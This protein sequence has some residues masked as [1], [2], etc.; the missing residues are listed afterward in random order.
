MR[1][2]VTHTEV[3]P[4]SSRFRARTKVRE[5]LRSIISY[6]S[7][8]Y[9]QPI[10]ECEMAKLSGMSTFRFSKAFRAV[11]GITFRDYLSDLRLA[12]S[13]R[14]LEN[15]RISVTDV[16]ALSGFNDPSYFA[17]LFRAKVGVSPTSYRLSKRPDN[18]QA[19]VSS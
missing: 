15:P 3:L 5:R 6:I 13:R 16:A 9:T 4:E 14:L 10:T 11:Y 17:R 2:N 8:H 7:N 12:R 1:S 18:L 19:S